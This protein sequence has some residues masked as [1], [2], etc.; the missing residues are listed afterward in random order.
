MLMIR[1]S[2]NGPGIAEADMGNIFD[3]FFTT[4]A[5][6]KGTGLGLSVCFMIVQSLGG[7]IFAESQS[8]GGTVITIYLPLDPGEKP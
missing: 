4:K 2:D 3:P 5:S 8:G 1:F 7:R 6:G